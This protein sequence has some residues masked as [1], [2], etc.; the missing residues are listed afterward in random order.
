MKKVKENLAVIF[1]GKGWET[2]V[3][4]LFD[5]VFFFVEMGRITHNCEIY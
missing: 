3:F 5:L 2:L 1:L 4:L